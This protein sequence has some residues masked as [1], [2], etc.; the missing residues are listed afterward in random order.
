[1]VHQL[2]FGATIT[3]A[4]LDQI[5][6]VQEH[7]DRN[8]PALGPMLG[9]NPVSEA[10]RPPERK[11]GLYA[12]ERSYMQPSD[13]FSV[14]GIALHVGESER[15]RSAGRTLDWQPGVGVVEIATSTI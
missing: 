7:C 10:H 6:S 8:E 9:W 13:I 3:D 1:M 14:A 12:F 15:V 4:L 5:K 11:W 2:P